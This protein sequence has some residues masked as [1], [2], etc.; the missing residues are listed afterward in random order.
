MAQGG[1]LPDVIR[2]SDEEETRISLALSGP[3][4]AARRLLGGYLGLRGKRGGC[5]LIAGFEGDAESVARRR[6]LAVRKLREGGAA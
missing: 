1:A 3:S 2:V 4:G 6:A 5:V